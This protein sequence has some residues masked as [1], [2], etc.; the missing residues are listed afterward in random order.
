MAKGNLVTF[1]MKM[2]MA[3]I[4]D[5]ILDFTEFTRLGTICR[6]DLERILLALLLNFYP[7]VRVKKKQKALK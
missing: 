5:V 4:Y 6:P 7:N 2:I 1:Q 3:V